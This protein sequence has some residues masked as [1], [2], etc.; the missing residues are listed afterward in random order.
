MDKH[1]NN[2]YA[3]SL[4]VSEALAE[5]LK[6]VKAE[7]QLYADRETNFNRPVNARRKY[8]LKDAREHA[9]YAERLLREAWELLDPT[10]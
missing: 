2:G 1:T 4:L 9:R 8:T 7:D 6:V 5:V 3:A 10:L